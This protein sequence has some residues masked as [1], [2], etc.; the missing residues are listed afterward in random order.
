MEHLQDIHDMPEFERL[1][2]RHFFEVYKDLEPG[3][4]VEAI[5]WSGR[6]SA[7]AEIERCSESF[8]AVSPVNTVR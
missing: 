7:E 6:A 5:R 3:K 1:E 4:I 8:N 2:I